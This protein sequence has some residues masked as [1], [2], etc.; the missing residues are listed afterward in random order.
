MLS[1]PW[2]SVSCW[3]AKS[4]GALL[5]ASHPRPSK[6][7]AVE[8]GDRL[9]R[10]TNSP[11]VAVERLGIDRF[12]GAAYTTPPTSW[13]GAGICG[14][15]AMNRAT[16]ATVCPNEASAS[17]D[18]ARSSADVNR[19]VAMIDAELR[20]EE[21]VGGTNQDSVAVTLEFG[22]T[23]I[24]LAS[25][26]LQAGGSLRL[27]QLADEPLD[28]VVEGRSIARG[29]LVAVE[30][31]LGI[32][33]VELL[34][35]L[36]AWLVLGTSPS[37]AQ[38][39]SG[40]F[41]FDN[42]S[43]RLE[44]PFGTVRG[45]RASLKTEESSVIP[46]SRRTDP[47]STDLSSGPLLPPRSDFTTRDANR[48]QGNAATSWSATV[49]PLLLVVGLIVVG[50]RWLKSRSP[51]ATRGLPAEVFEMLGRKAI[52]ARTS[53]VL[54]RCGS[55]LL[56]LSQSPHGLQTL[57]EITDPVEIDCLAGLC[58]STQRDQTLAE[59]FRAMLHRPTNPKP[60][61]SPQTNPLDDRLAAR[62]MSA[63][64]ATS[65]SMS[66]VRP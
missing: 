66:E 31:R 41:V 12:S 8:P 33:I 26:P 13:L 65:A 10:T 18:R 29:E 52:D 58:R 3:W 36:V 51:V 20:S 60:T 63:R 4:G 28:L 48:A 6:L 21:D 34:L 62:L 40:A 47:P 32:R 5:P 23:T 15:D 50:A 42:E 19:W 38:E 22:R 11:A 64:S 35:L 25:Q 37:L 49:W 1:I 55:R 30:G 45:S 9:P 16:S 24:D 2:K 39:R 46:S 27:D 7:P 56:L 53:V 17:R 44:T 59:T 43:E 61:T 57:A 14:R 54:A